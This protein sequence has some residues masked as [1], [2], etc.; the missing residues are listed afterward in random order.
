MESKKLEWLIIGILAVALISS[1]VFYYY[2]LDKKSSIVT[3]P[4]EN[5]EVERLLTNYSELEASYNKAIGEIEKQ[6]N[7]GD[8]GI[9]ILKQ[10]LAQILDEIKEEKKQIEAK[11]Y[12]KNIDS[13]QFHYDQA[14]QMKQMLKMSKE[15]LVERLAEVQRRNKDLQISN[16]KLLTRNEKLVLKVKK[17]NNYVEREKSKNQALKAEVIK[18][19]QRINKIAAKG[20]SAKQML[21][22]LKKEKK[23]FEQKLEESTKMIEIQTEQI[24]ELGVIVKKV[25]AECYFVYEEGNPDEE[26]KIFL[27]KGG[28][29]KRYMRYFTKKKPDV[30]FDFTINDYMFEEGS[31]R[32]DFKLFDENEIEL[33]STSKAISSGVLKFIVPNKHFKSNGKYAITLF[34]GQDNLLINDKYEFI[35][36]K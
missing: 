3:K 27:T 12:V 35:I 34:E 18:V 17:I 31:E 13:L 28:V 9:D 1:T 4:A 26:A 20:D 2:S 7:V 33:Y 24:S 10:N 22:K 14:E 30:H 21:D 25:N 8:V 32:V 11:K 15:V 19:Q 29:S 5:K 6:V 23:Y 16:Q 36:S